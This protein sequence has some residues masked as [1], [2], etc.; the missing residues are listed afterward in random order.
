M[1]STFILHSRIQVWNPIYQLN[2]HPTVRFIMF[3]TYPCFSEFITSVYVTC[4]PAYEVPNEFYIE[5]ISCS[6]FSSCESSVLLCF[7]LLKC[8]CNDDTI[9][10]AHYETSRSLDLSSLLNIGSL[11]LLQDFWPLKNVLFAHVIEFKL[12]CY[13]RDAWLV[14]YLPI[15]HHLLLLVTW[16]FICST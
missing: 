14:D 10:P 15:N 11:Y 2:F 8:S 7:C 1:F 16:N 4:W 9:Y 13:S 12:Q 6:A 3:Q 5:G